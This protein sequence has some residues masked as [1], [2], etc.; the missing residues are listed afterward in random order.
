MIHWY[1]KFLFWKPR[2][3]SVPGKLI[4]LCSKE[5]YIIS[6]IIF[7]LLYNRWKHVNNNYIWSNRQLL[8]H[9]LCKMLEI[10]SLSLNDNKSVYFEFT[11]SCLAS[12]FYLVKIPLLRP[13]RKIKRLANYYNNVPCACANHNFPF[14]P[15]DRHR[16]K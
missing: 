8:L 5:Q 2:S 11:F 15:R 3:I 10:Q 9:K 12:T 13:F 16:T 1:V 7:H 14:G 4:L 6:S